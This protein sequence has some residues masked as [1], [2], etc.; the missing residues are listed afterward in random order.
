MGASPLHLPS[1]KASVGRIGGDGDPLSF[2]Q[3]ESSVDGPWRDEPTQRVWLTRL[4]GGSIEPERIRVKR[5]G[6]SVSSRGFR[7]FESV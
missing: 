2:G 3:A 1:Q 4:T 5:V 7:L 6:L